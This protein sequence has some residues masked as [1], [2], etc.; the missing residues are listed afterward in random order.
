MKPKLPTLYTQV[1]NQIPIGNST[2]NNIG[3]L[4]VDASMVA[5]YFG[6][7]IDP[8]TLAKSVVYAF[9]GP[10]N[11]GVRTLWDWSQL[12]KLF[13]DIIYKGQIQTP[14]ILNDTQINQ[15][16]DR[17]STGFPVFLQIQTDAIPEHW[18]LAVDFNGDDFLCA[19]PLK[20]PPIVHPITDYGLPPREVIYAYAWYEG[21][22]PVLNDPLKE[23]LRQHDILVQQLDETKQGL[24]KAQTDFK[25]LQ[26][27]TT[28]A[29]ADKDSEC[30]RKLQDYKTKTTNFIN[31][32][33]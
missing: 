18:L 6:H 31:G 5:T 4:T 15:I 26:I 11:T 24:L 1:G 8:S 25:D 21:K 19:D 22:L 20:N 23:C 12:T 16:K 29:L 17:I 32:L 14:D 28:K 9:N 7:V 33:V 13:P 30:L 27:S 10:N 2:I 3:C